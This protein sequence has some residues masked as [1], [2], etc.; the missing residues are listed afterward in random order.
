MTDRHLIGEY[1]DAHLEMETLLRKSGPILETAVVTNVNIYAKGFTQVGPDLRDRLTGKTI[2]EFVA[3]RRKSN[4]N[5]YAD[6][7]PDD[8]NQLMHVY[9]EE[10]FGPQ[11]SPKT[12]TRLYNFMNDPP[13]FKALAKQWGCD[14]VRMLPGTRPGTTSGTKADEKPAGP[15][16]SQNPWSEQYLKHH[17][18]ID[19][20]AEQQR[21][22]KL[23]SAVARNTALAA[24]VSVFGV[25][26]K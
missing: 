13:R 11:C 23:G 25:P 9:A 16:L 10:A 3:G 4:P 20:L 22:I 26:L 5:D 7:V 21:L 12:V 8:P 2:E 14:T 1:R 6:W 19:A 24:G 17:S 18:P 15:S